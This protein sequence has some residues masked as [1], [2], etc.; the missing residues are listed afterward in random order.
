MNCI[1]ASPKSIT[2]STIA[3][4]VIIAALA[5]PAC[6]PP[7]RADSRMSEIATAFLADPEQSTC[8]KSSPKRRARHPVADWHDQ[9][10]RKE[11]ES[12][13]VPK[14][15]TP[16][17][18]PECLVL[19]AA[20]LQLA[21]QT[22]ET[23]ATTAL[24]FYRRAAR[25][26]WAAHRLGQRKALRRLKTLNTERL[27][28]EA[29]A[30]RD[31]V[32]IHLA[33]EQSEIRGKQKSDLLYKTMWYKLSPP[34]LLRIQYQGQTRVVSFTA[35]DVTA[36]ENHVLSLIEEAATKKALYG[37]SDVDGVL[38]GV[39]LADKDED[40]QRAVCKWLNK[41]CPKPS[42]RTRSGAELE[43]T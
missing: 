11:N 12:S 7:M 25:L 40:L 5:V 21:R 31:V 27:A 22:K 4:V 30:G 26:L 10:C 8:K 9:I 16:R 18:G 37:V 29:L 20:E 32:L 17:T 14:K 19:A 38:R 28:L 41:S 24:P 42:V 34:M 35:Q 2:F 36:P 1:A 39:L 23:A 3:V 43:Q 6:G 15:E 33:Y 13:R